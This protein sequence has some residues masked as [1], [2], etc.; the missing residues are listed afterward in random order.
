MPAALL[1]LF[2][3][4]LTA[5]TACSLGKWLLR[6]MPFELERFEEDALGF[7]LGSACLSPIL[8]VLAILH[9]ARPLV[10]LV[11]CG[12]LIAA[13][14]RGGAWR[15]LHR[16]SRGPSPWLPCALVLFAV[17]TFVYFSHAMAPEVSPDGSTYHLG[18]VSRFARAGGFERITTN[19]YANL[20]EGIELMFLLAF[21]F[22]Q[23]SSAAM[24]HFCFLLT[25]P[26][27]I[28]FYGRRI[29][30][31]IAGLGAAL[32]V[33]LS[34][35]VGIDGAS[36]YNDV[37]HAAVLFALFY[38][39]ELRPSSKQPDDPWILLAIGMLAGFAFAVK[40]T[41]FLAVPYALARIVWPRPNLRRFVLFSLPVCLQVFPWL[42]KNWLWVDNPF[43]PFANAWFPNPYVHLFFEIS[44]RNLMQNFGMLDS[45]WSIP[46]EVTV[47]GGRLGGLLGP[48]FLLA[49]IALVSLRLR[50][51]RRLLIAWAVFTAV[52]Y[53][54]TSTRF[55]IPGLPFAALAM[56]LT[57]ELWRPALALVVV[58]HALLSWPSNIP[59]YSVAN[60]KL[61]RIPL[62]YGLR[63]KPEDVWLRRNLP[64]YDAA[65]ALDRLVP[66][67]GIVYSPNQVVEAYTSREV[68]VGFQSAEGDRV[69]DMLEVPMT[70]GF[71][72]RLARRIRF[73]ARE[74]RRLR[75]VQT[76]KA[77]SDLWS[78]NELR[79]LSDG[80]E[81]KPQSV[82]TQPNP[83]DAAFLT[84]GSPV[85]R[86][87]SWEPAKPGM[88]IDVDLGSLRRIDTVQLDSSPDQYQTQLA[89]ETIDSAGRWVTVSGAVYEE[90]VNSPA[91]ISLR[92]E[93]A[94]QVKLRGVGYLLIHNFD[95]NW[96]DYRDH[97]AEWGFELLEDMTTV[98]IYRIR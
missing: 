54:N 76:A 46:L 64:G 56:A 19:I 96:Q 97:A 81:I 55:L 27:M 82:R 43:S 61:T 84:D 25:L 10:F 2:G 15:P 7:V 49:P 74:L 85:T 4:A 89:L 37:A 22:G 80:K 60:W 52:Y 63:L 50:E 58:V 31:P 77:V 40:Y 21:T 95:Y 3:A 18:L 33:Y 39:L 75:V 92:R 47:R 94:R 9:A 98:Q 93:A 88:F 67:R 1:I 14:I 57:L 73:P 12:G 79:L 51:G 53:T 78:V 45:Y 32:L 5:A 48:V 66:P 26:V 44:Y 87:R 90:A 24:V 59:R 70:E 29:G 20:S 62:L 71:D 6:Q 41:A 83:W 35:V 30:H 8:F 65:R 28:A 23:H 36:A 38:L 86:W 11:V 91:T 42:I 72:A 16:S 34:P 13:S 17:F 69:R 68:W